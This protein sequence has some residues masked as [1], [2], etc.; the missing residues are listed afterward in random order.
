V[1]SSDEPFEGFP[2][3]TL[4]FL[5]GL[6]ENNER[7]WFNE[8]RA[9]YQ[10]YYLQPSL[11]FVEAIGPRLISEV[12]PETR[13]EARV[14]GSLFRIHRDI[15]FSRDKTPYKS[16]IDLWFR[17][18][19]RQGWDSPGFFLRMLPDELVLGAGIHHFSPE[20]M[21]AY[22]NAVVDPTLGSS[23][24]AIEGQ[25]GED[26]QLGLPTRQSVPRGFDAQHERAKY[27]LYEGLAVYADGPIPPEA[28]SARF[29]DYCIERY[30]DMAPLNGWL[31]E[32]L[33]RPPSDGS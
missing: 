31:R 13:Y 10:R 33:P 32:A 7:E 17:E 22:R 2:Q 1:T 12:T 27:L 8:H 23:L 15:R 25:L 16:H 28:H 21:A 3:E 5:R 6:S 19:D 4:T 26:Y 20:Q 14:G 29:V 11:A 24:A 9:E 30:K 18:G